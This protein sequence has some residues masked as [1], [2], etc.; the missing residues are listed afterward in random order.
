MRDKS[1]QCP[2]CNQ[3]Y[4]S[5]PGFPL[6]PGDFTVCPGCAAILIL[7]T[8]LAPR[9]PNIHEWCDVLADPELFLILKGTQRRVCAEIYCNRLPS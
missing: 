2:Q 9:V 1:V 8:T 5:P 6:D 7:D 3:E 4:N